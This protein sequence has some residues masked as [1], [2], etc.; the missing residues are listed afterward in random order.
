[1]RIHARPRLRGIAEIKQERGSRMIEAIILICGLGL[2]P[3]AC[4][5]RSADDVI[6]VEVQPTVCAMA[7]QSVIAGQA[8]A[9][10]KGRLMKVICGRKA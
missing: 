4:T 2:A 1:M 9:R 8:G 5:E 6:R 3:Q 10:A 7:A